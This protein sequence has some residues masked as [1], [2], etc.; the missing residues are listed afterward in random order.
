[1]VGPLGFT[2]TDAKLRR[3]GL[4]Y[5]DK[6][7]ITHY[8]GLDDFFARTQGEYYFFTTKADKAYTEPH[9]PDQCYIVFGRE[10]QGLPET[11][12]KANKGHLVR[13]PMVSDL[14]SLNLSNSV[15][16]GAYE[17]LRQWEFPGLG[18]G[19]L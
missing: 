6:L 16:V 4:D 10:D 9:Y 15:A 2:I 12:L 11:L 14:R 19:R 1:M 3:A 7:D 18:L 13:L 8:D 17:V 5:W